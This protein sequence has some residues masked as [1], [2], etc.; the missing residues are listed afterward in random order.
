MKVYKGFTLVELMLV[1]F[2][3]SLFS[4]IAFTSYSKIQTRAKEKVL[5]SIV[6]NFQLALE[7]YFLAFSTY[8]EGDNVSIGEIESILVESGDLKEPHLNPFTG[9]FFSSS[10]KSGLSLYFFDSE[11]L[12]YRVEVYGFLNE[13]SILNIEH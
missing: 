5:L 1:L 6:N 9:N 2:I 3:I 4:T 13:Y 8:P 10:D 12:S 11:L 7:S